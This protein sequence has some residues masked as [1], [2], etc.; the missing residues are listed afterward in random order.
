M[1]EREAFQAMQAMTDNDV[2]DAI[3]AILDEVFGVGR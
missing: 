2:F 1:D 3:D